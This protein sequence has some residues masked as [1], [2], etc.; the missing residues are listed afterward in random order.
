MDS[1]VVDVEGQCVRRMNKSEADALLFEG[2]STCRMSESM[3]KKAWMYDLH[4]TFEGECSA[5]HAWMHP[6]PDDNL[7]EDCHEKFSHEWHI[8]G[9]MP[10]DVKAKLDCDPDSCVFSPADRAHGIEWITNHPSC[11]PH[12]RFRPDRLLMY[13]MRDRRI[14]MAFD[15]AVFPGE[16]P[17][18]D[19]MLRLLYRN[20]GVTYNEFVEAFMPDDEEDEYVD[21]VS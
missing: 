15:I 5:C 16:D 21:V 9:D 7:C 8:V 6:T 19:T 12:V 13:V 2:Q 1:L 18:K 4:R 14:H 17:Y 11:D 20:T 10:D 3:P